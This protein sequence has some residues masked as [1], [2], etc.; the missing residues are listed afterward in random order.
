MVDKIVLQR[1]RLA[2]IFI[3][4]SIVVMGTASLVQSMSLDYYSVLGTLEKVIPASIALGCIGWVMGLILDR[5]SRK[6]QRGYA[7]FFVDE[8]KKSKA[9][10]V[11]TSIVDEVK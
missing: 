3:S 2:A 9:Q 10:D 6:Q 7:N 11:N 5:P 1:K 4:F 8:I